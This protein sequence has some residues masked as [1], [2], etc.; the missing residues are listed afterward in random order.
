ML[1]G[2]AG[3]AVAAL[4]STQAPVLLGLAAGI[5]VT[6]GCV[7]VLDCRRHAVPAGVCCYLGLGVATVAPGIP[8][9]SA[10]A[11]GHAVA[12]SGAL[13]LLGVE[14]GTRAGVVLHGGGTDATDYGGVW[15]VAAATFAA[16]VA[17][18]RLGRAGRALVGTLL[19]A[20][21]GTHVGT[22]VLEAGTVHQASSLVP[23]ATLGFLVFPAV[24][25][26]GYVSPE[27]HGSILA[28]AGAWLRKVVP[29][30]G[31]TLPSDETTSTGA[32]D[33]T[34]GGSGHAPDDAPS[35]PARGESSGAAGGET[36]S[37]A[38]TGPASSHD[39]ASHPGDP[40]RPT[41][42]ARPDTT[43]DSTPSGTTPDGR[44]SGRD[45]PDDWTWLD[46]GGDGQHADDGDDTDAHPDAAGTGE[47]A[48]TAATDTDIDDVRPPCQNCGSETSNRE[49]RFVV[50]DPLCT[51]V[52]CPE[53]QN[54]RV[55]TLRTTEECLGPEVHGAIADADA[56][57]ACGDP[58]ASLEAHPV[59]P[60]SAG[61]HR[62]PNNVL[63]LCGECHA[64]VEDHLLAA[65]VREPQQQ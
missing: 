20:L 21:V 7:V 45:R 18:W 37:G 51:V 22:V 25:T 19:V 56:C 64:A 62:H 30:P 8:P 16:P 15:M 49:P 6:A 32:S 24:D 38:A 9:A 60:L 2:V 13:A 5:L 58:T 55:R 44:S 3:V 35:G 17:L 57:T 34:A 65:G 1:A 48:A 63:A 11:I 33:G 47:S 12:G 40:S 36:P 52:L 42:T 46:D 28:R 27:P 39:G 4:A 31:E 53:C 59:V 29:V 23:V 61:G 41:T 50:A 54:R 26:V 43:G 14:V 10:D